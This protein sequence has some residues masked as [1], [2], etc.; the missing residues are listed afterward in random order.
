MARVKKTSA[1]AYRSPKAPAL[2]PA[3][4]VGAPATGQK[5]RRQRRAAA[6]VRKDTTILQTDQGPRAAWSGAKP[7]FPK[8]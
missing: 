6:A 2:P 1:P 3:L 5:T 8:R 7:K 4:P